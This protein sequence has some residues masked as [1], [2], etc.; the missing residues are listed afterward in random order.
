MTT[1]P[2]HKNITRHIS[3]T[4]RVKAAMQPD[5]NTVNVLESGVDQLDFL[6]SSIATLAIAD[7]T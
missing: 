5:C 7:D 2:G 3:C 6:S 1:F 4:S